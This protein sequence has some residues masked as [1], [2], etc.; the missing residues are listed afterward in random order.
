MPGQAHPFSSTASDDFVVATETNNADSPARLAKEAVDC[1]VTDYHMPG[2]D[3]LE[4]WG[5]YV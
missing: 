1:V 3:S 4:F 2:I 5:P